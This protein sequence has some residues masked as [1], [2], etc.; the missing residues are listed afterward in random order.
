LGWLAGYGR[1]ERHVAWSVQPE[2]SLQQAAET[3]H[4]WREEGLLHSNQR[5]FSLSPELGAYAAWFSPGERQFFDHRYSL[6]SAAARDY[7]LVCRAL[8]PESAPARP[9]SSQA[10]RE[11]AKEWKKILREHDVSIVVYYDRNPQ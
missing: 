8:Q 1:E 4:R 6:F 10:A 5:V 3:L 7:E 9:V 2:P 11:D